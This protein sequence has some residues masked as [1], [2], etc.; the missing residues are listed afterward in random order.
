MCDSDTVVKKYSTGSIIGGAVGSV[1]GLGLMV[2]AGPEILLGAGVSAIAVPTA[3]A[4][5]LSSGLG[6]WIKHKC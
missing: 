5:G 2:A 6:H 4:G 3:V 1:V